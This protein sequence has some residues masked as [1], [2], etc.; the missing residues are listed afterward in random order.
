MEMFMESSFH[1]DFTGKRNE[2]A[3]TAAGGPAAV[4]F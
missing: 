2:Y 3:E 1:A 4:G